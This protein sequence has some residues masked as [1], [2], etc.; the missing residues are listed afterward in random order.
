MSKIKSIIQKQ[1]II[2]YVISLMVSMVSFNGN[3]APFGLAIFA[4]CCSNRKP[5]GFVY[6][7]TLIGT[8]IK[9]GLSGFLSYLISSILFILLIIIIRPNFEEDE[10][11]EKQKLGLYVF[12]ASFSIQAAK[13]LFTGFLIYDLVTSIAMGLITYIFYKIFVNSISVI[14]QIRR[15]QCI[16]CRR[17]DGSKPFSLHCSSVTKG[18]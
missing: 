5:V 15:K 9:F 8:F 18:N 6:I 17:S 3:M 1:D 14:T 12:I 4:A 13:M 2:L 7:L 16:F 10:R 11:N